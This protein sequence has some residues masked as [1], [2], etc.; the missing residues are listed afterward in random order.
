[1]ANSNR[2][3]VSESKNGYY[4]VRIPPALAAARDLGGKTVEWNARSATA[5]ELRE[6][7]D[8]G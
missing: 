3:T 1:M 2:R 6:V 8:D 7:D 4:M 5:L